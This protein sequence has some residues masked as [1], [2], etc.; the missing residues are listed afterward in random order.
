M[1]RR[2]SPR[3]RVIFFLF[4]FS[5]LCAYVHIVIVISFF[6]FFFCGYFKGSL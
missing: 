6:F 1:P 2:G 5:A 3:C 4:S